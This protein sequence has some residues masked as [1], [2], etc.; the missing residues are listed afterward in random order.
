MV[1]KNLV[2]KNGNVKELVITQKEIGKGIKMPYTVTKYK[3]NICHKEFD[4]YN[5]AYNHEL[6]CHRCKV[7]KHAYYV[8]GCE[9]ACDY[10]KECNPP[11]YIK[12][13]RKQDD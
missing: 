6:I 8:Y 9:F 1:E 13:E 2:Q 10:S 11:K 12:F 3:C 7:C 5:D 4:R